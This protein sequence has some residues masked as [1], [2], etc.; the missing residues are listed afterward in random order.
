MTKQLDIQEIQKIIPHRYPMLL[1]DRV[2]KL[3]VK[4]ELT[5]VT[6]TCILK[7]SCKMSNILRYRF[8]EIDLV[9]VFISLKEIVLCKDISKRS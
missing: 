6:T 7:K 3:K 9:I 8:S 2:L 5:L 1:I 4:P